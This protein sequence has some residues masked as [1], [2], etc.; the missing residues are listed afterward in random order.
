MTVGGGSIFSNFYYG[1]NYHEVESP[2]GGEWQSIKTKG[3]DALES[4]K[5]AVGG[6]YNIKN[7][8]MMKPNTANKYID[9]QILTASFNDDADLK[10]KFDDWNTT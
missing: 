4:G 7:I 10:Q 2:A 1:D 6:Y 9:I 5:T 8:Q 3:I